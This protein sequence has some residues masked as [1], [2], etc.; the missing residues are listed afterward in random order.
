[1]TSERLP[2]QGSR[3]PAEPA[4]DAEATAPAAEATGEAVPVAT[5]E[6]PDPE[7]RIKQLEEE[8]LRLMADFANY[9]KRVNRDRATWTRD[10]V[11]DAVGALLPVLDNLEHAIASFEGDVKEPAVY[12]EG[13]ELVQRELLRVL[14]NYQL[15]PIRPQVG[16]PFDPEL[17]QAISVVPS[18]EVTQETVAAVART[19]YRLGEN[20]LRPAQ[21]VVQKPQ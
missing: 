20:V 12:R 16:D 15:E 18:A 14:G 2:E 6:A 1:M 3:E 7:A 21:V 8:K 10:A 5:D 9:Q 13:V 11:R 17:H 19:G 4:A